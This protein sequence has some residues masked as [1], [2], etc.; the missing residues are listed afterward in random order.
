MLEGAEM[1]DCKST[2]FTLAALAASEID[3][4]LLAELRA[5]SHCREELA[6]IAN[7]VRVAQ[8]ALRAAEPAEDF[9]LGYHERLQQRLTFGV[10]KRERRWFAPLT[11]S[12]GVPL[13]LAVAMVLLLVASCAFSVSQY[14]RQ[15]D[16]P[17]VA[18]EVERAPVPLI[19]EE[20]VTRIVYVNR[21]RPRSR[22][23]D[24]DDQLAPKDG[25]VAGLSGFKPTSEV[26][27]TIIKGSNVDEK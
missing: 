14:F 17:P 25:T 12:V 13:P 23:T 3:A 27:L 2:R 16:L 9:W 15:V 10:A 19:R 24:D 26:K 22:Q 20:V 6:S 7:T 5:C 4:G 21:V 8:D 1:H 11:A 18:V